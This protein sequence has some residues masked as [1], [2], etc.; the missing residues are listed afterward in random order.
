[1]GKVLILWGMLLIGQFLLA[2]AV[3]YQNMKAGFGFVETALTMPPLLFAFSLVLFVVS[4]LQY[5][6]KR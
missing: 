2:A 4:W 5:R 1:M 6:S 3:M